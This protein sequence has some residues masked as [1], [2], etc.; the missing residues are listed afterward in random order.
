MNTELKTIFI[1]TSEFGLPAF[2]ALHE[3]KRFNIIVCV[4]QPDKEAGRGKK[5]TASPI[6]QFAQ[7]QNIKVL[8]PMRIIEIQD[9]LMSMEPDLIIV[10]SYGQIIPQI[11]L[12]IP[13]YNCLNIHGSLLPKYRGSSCVQAAIL[14]GDSESGV[15]IMEM[16][17]KLD[18][19]PI[20]RQ[21][22]IR[23]SVTETSAS[24]HDKL[25]LVA[26]EIICQTCLDYVKQ[27]AI[28]RAQNHN[29][30]TYVRNIK[31]GD[32]HIKWESSSLNIDRFVRAMQTWPGA[33]S[34]ITVKDTDKLLKII[35]ARIS[36]SHTKHEPGFIYVENGRILVNT[37]DGN[38]QIDE[39][40]LEGAKKMSDKEFLN[41]Y[42]NLL[43]KK[44]A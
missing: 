22:K 37:L 23:I 35:K 40:Q 12:D 5:M 4:T 20:I 11:I 38:L 8:Q 2:R 33:Y 30:A 39:L 16:D 34:H 44:L 17:S 15:T 13:K 18:S 3:S 19:G 21:E 42:K 27:K 31:K 32:G 29:L 14:N 26:G 28:P 1:G 7:T 43:Q 9:N 25:S 36:T 41:G 10:A 24:L 6:K